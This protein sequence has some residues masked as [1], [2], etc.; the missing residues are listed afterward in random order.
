MVIEVSSLY[1]GFYLT[2]ILYQVLILGRAGGVI[3]CMKTK[4]LMI[5]ALL[6]KMGT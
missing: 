3:T 5:L 6:F 2:R 1:K 4:I